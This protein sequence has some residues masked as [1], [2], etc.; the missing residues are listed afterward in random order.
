M[1]GLTR[2]NENL[3]LEPYLAES[4]EINKE[5]NI[6]KIKIKDKIKWSDG[7]KL[8]ASHFI[9][10]WER[11][12][13]PATGA[14]YAYF[15]YDIKNAKKYNLGELGDFNLVGV[16]ATDERNIKIQRTLL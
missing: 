16:K 14:D 12:L 10:S 3:I 1:G 9:D 4:W 7:K 13:N 5:K 2:F 11:L 8:L 15:L 6:I